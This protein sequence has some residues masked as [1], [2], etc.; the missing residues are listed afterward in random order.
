[1]SILTMQANQAPPRPRRSTGAV[2]ATATVITAI[3]VVVAILAVTLLKAHVEVG[4]LWHAAAH[5]RR[6]LDLVLFDGWDNPS[7]WYAPWTNTFGNVA[8][9]VPFGLVAA[10]ARDVFSRRAHPVLLGGLLGFGFSL[11]IEVTQYVLALGYTDVDDLLMN[12][13]GAVLGAGLAAR[14]NA[15]DRYAAVATLSIGAVVV[16]TVMASG[17]VSGA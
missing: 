1:M 13:L 7:V 9:F 3:I 12:T 11:F 17:L 16:V 10:M 4:G 8:L 15:A 14:L 5:Q 2:P 6:D